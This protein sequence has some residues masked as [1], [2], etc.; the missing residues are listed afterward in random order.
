MP[1]R[2]LEIADTFDAHGSG[3]RWAS[4]GH[5]SLAHL[6]LVSAKD[7]FRTEALGAHLAA[8]TRCN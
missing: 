8:C 1:R 2:A 6:K 4:A 5:L 7:A 3:Y